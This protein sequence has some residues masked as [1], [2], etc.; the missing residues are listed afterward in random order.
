MHLEFREP[1]RCTDAEFGELAD[2]II[3]PNTGHV[4][5]L[6]VQPHHRHDEARL[7]AFD[8]VQAEGTDRG[9]ALDYTLEAV[10]ALERVQQVEVVEPGEARKLE[11]ASDVGIEHVVVPSSYDGYGLDGAGFGTP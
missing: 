2:V 9:I 5:H 11:G 4:T 1:V 3:D 6:V 10:Q 7:V 8:R